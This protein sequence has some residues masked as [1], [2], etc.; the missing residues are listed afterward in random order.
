MDVCPPYD[1]Q[2]RSAG[3]PSDVIAT[4]LAT[5]IV[6]GGIGIGRAISRSKN[7]PENTE[8]G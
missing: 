6:F 5:A 7:P 8:P 2:V 1:I 3:Y 4:G